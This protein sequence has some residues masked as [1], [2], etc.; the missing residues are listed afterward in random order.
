MIYDTFK[1][2][3]FKW[4]DSANRESGMFFIDKYAEMESCLNMTLAL[5]TT[6]YFR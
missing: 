1:D 5:M 2:V 6:R 4:T 3:R